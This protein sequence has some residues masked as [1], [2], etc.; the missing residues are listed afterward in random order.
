MKQIVQRKNLEN[1]HIVNLKFQE[2]YNVSGW[3][4]KKNLAYCFFFVPEF[5]LIEDVYG[6]N[7]GKFKGND[8][9]D[10]I[11]SQVTFQSFF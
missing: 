9:E 1:K 8:L 3:V 6:G 4:K 7:M 11:I 5:R 10:L 2:N